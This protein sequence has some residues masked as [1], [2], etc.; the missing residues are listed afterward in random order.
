MRSLGDVLSWFVGL[1]VLYMCYPQQMSNVRSA[2]L[3]AV[4]GLALSPRCPQIGAWSRGWRFPAVKGPRNEQ[5]GEGIA[6][7]ASL[8]GRRRSRRPSAAELRRLHVRVVVPLGLRQQVALVG[9]DVGIAGLEVRP[10][11]RRHVRHGGRRTAEIRHALALEVELVRPWQGA[12]RQKPVE[13]SIAIH[14]VDADVPAHESAC[15]MLR[16]VVRVDLAPAF[17]S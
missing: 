9:A 12:S 15:G 16:R 13:V 2:I 8:L 14:G 1:H 6:P 11:R 10:A 3:C 4:G 17:R 5:G 7:L